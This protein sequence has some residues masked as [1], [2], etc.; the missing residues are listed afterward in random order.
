ME[1][2]IA[3]PS[4]YSPINDQCQ[5]PY[6]CAVFA[7]SLNYE[8]TSEYI[9]RKLKE[10]QVKGNSDTVGIT[11]QGSNLNEIFPFSSLLTLFRPCEVVV[12]NSLFDI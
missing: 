3:N 6:A 2:D 9:F 12:E 5:T 11:V 10:T 7:V 4:L 1:A 8:A